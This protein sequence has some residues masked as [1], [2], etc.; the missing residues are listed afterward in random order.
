MIASLYQSGSSVI[1]GERRRA[2]DGGRS[3]HHAASS[4]ASCQMANGRSAGSRRMCWRLPCQMKLLAAH[5]ILDRE[6]AWSGRPHSHSGTSMAASWTLCGSRLTATRIMS[7]ATGRPLAVEQDLVVA[8]RIEGQ[9]RDAICSAGCGRRIRFSAV[10][11]ADDVARRGEVPRA[12]LVFLGVEIFLA[13]RQRRRLAELEA[14]IDAP[15]AGQ[16]RASA[17]RI[18]KPAGPM[19]AGRRD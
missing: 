12:D 17:A 3:V 11:S 19:S 7:R 8:G 13:A 18:R 14:G 4:G 10:I 9:A 5:Q 2:A 6:R 15:Q 16:R 1:G